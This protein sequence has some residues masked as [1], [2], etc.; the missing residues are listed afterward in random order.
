MINGE[1]VLAVIPA[2][3]GSKRCPRKNLRPFRGEPLLWWSILC[4]R[5]SRYIDRI[6]LSTEDQEIRDY[7]KQHVSVIHRPDYLASDTASNEDVLRHVLGLIETR[8]VVLLQPASP[9]RW[10]LDIDSC[11]EMAQPI[12]GVERPVISVRRSDGSKNGAVYVCRSKW[13]LEGH[14]FG[15]PFI[16]YLMPDDRSLDIDYPEQLEDSDDA[17]KAAELIEGDRRILHKVY[18]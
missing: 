16:P 17:R 2:R 3:G 4:A 12:H 13:L 6:V 9:L 15:E 1:T 11:I 18:G 7:A 8:W 10:S 14:N 5:D